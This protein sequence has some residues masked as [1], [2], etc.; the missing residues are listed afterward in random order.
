MHIIT[1]SD[2]VLRDLD[3]LKQISQTYAAVTFT[4]TTTDDALGKKVEPGAPLVSQRLK[5]MATLA[6][7]GILTGVSMMPIL[8]F[9]EDS[10]DNIRAIVDQAHTHGAKYI[11]AAFGMTLRDRQRAY[12]YTQLD[13][14]FPGVRQQYERAFGEKYSASANNARKLE[15]VFREL[16]IRYGIATRMPQFTPQ[17]KSAQPRLF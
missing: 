15:Q 16:C 1:K 2:L 17:K 9:I 8:P 11:I 3:T 5:A 4:I 13:R 6:A 10:A 14:L 12:Y 7:N